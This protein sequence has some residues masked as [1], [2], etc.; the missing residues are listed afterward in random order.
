MMPPEV[1]DL[2]PQPTPEPASQGL[3]ALIDGAIDAQDEPAASELPS[4]PE[5]DVHPN[6]PSRTRDGKFRRKTDA[7]VE[8][9]EPGPAEP[10][11][12]TAETPEPQ[13][14]EQSLEAPSRWSDAD[15]A[16]FAQQPRE[17]QEFLVSRSKEMEADY[18]RK[19]QEVAETR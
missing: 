5:A 13:P 6:D 1:D 17:V 2:S 10:E 4:E 11:A 7:P 15:K 8:A 19:T 9:S 18:T 14:A 16:M 3:D 12:P